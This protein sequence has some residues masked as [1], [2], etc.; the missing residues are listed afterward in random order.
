M[1]ALV[2]ELYHLDIIQKINEGNI[3]ELKQL[4]EIEKYKNAINI[5]DRNGST[6]LFY[7][8]LR[9]CVCLFCYFFCYNVLYS[10]FFTFFVCK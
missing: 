1:P 2:T 10:F 5:C 8:G 6:P 3:K 7:A 4:L 9:F